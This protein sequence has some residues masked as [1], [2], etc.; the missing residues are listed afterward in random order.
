MTLDMSAAWPGHNT[1]AF[2]MAFDLDGPTGDAML[3]GSIWHKPEYFTFGSYGPYRALPRLLDLLDEYG[4]ATTFFIPTWNVENWPKQCQMIAERG[5]EIAYHGYKHESFYALKPDEQRAVMKKSSDIFNKYLG[6]RAAGFRTPSGDWH[7]ETPKILMEAG[8]T[9]S[10]SMRGDDR[11][12]LV[13]VDGYPQPL[14]EIPGHWELDDYAS[15][16]YTRN[17]NFPTGLDRT[18]SYELT[19]DNWC[20]EFD[21]AAD[22]NLCL[23]TIFHPKITGTPGRLMLL[24]KLFQHMK[25]RDHVWFARCHEIADW[26]LQE[27][28]HG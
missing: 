5:H 27:H 13:T 23:T 6:I 15:I 24:E 20:R 11:P 8:V 14:V 4:I 10:S 22:N 21:A 9:Y 25:K 18:A 19:L 28:H 1:S 2:A 26:W 3:D 17:P 12:Y 16:A 7:A